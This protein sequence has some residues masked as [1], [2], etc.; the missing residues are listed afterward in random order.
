MLTPEITWA[1]LH[2]VMLYMLKTFQWYSSS[3]PNVS[4]L[5]RERVDALYV[6]FVE[7]NLCHCLSDELHCDRLY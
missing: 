2:F 1:G 5:E 4:D 3:C 6:R 7:T